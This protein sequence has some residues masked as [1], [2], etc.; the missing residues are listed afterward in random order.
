MISLCPGSFDKERKRERERESDDTVMSNRPSMTLARGAEA[1]DIYTSTSWSMMSIF[2]MIGLSGAFS[3]THCPPLLVLPSCT[4][5]TLLRIL[6]DVYDSVCAVATA[7]LLATHRARLCVR[8]PRSSRAVRGP[9][10]GLHH[11]DPGVAIGCW[12]HC[13]IT[14]GAGGDC[15]V[16]SGLPAMVACTRHTSVV[17]MRARSARAVWEVIRVRMPHCDAR[18]VGWLPARK[19]RSESDVSVN[20]LRVFY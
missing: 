16:M 4:G 19:S 6:V 9:K 11:S 17:W 18:A 10:D 7:G 12:D 13:C 20:M 2:L 15:G 1:L 8:R 5:Y 14:G 3:L